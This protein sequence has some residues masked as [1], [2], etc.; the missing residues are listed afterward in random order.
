MNRL[1]P[2]PFPTDTD[3]A[4]KKAPKEA[5]IIYRAVSAG[6]GLIV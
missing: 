2:V 1:F 6:L 4:M 3:N 5:S